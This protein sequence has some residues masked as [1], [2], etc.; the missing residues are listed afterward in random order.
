MTNEEKYKYWEMLSDY[1]IDTAE[2]LVREKRWVYVSFLC[3][4]AIER[5]LKGMYVYYFGKEAPK[6]HNVNYLLSKIS[7]NELF[8]CKVG[9]EAFEAQFKKNE[10]FFDDLIFYY[11]SDYPFSYQKIMDRFISEET[12]KEI[13]SQTQDVLCWLKSLQKHRAKA[14]I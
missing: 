6:S 1:D 11:I 3:E 13:F 12:A 9:R 2:V 8:L 7:K 14:A 10:D 4:Q 5:M